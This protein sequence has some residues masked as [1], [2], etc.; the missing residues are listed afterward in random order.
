[1]AGSTTIETARELPPL[2]ES[3]CFVLAN[4]KFMSGWGSATGK[5]NVVILPCASLA[6][7]YV[8]AQNARDRSDMRRVRIVAY[9]KPRLQ[10]RG[11]LYSL[12]TRDDADRW[13]SPARPFRK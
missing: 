11:K 3:P 7:A 5:V 13:Y 9:K 2:S 8:V 10:S 12:M 6:E 4:D 1:M